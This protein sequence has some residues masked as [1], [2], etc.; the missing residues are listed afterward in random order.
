M[1][2]HSQTEISKDK[3]T[4]LTCNIRATCFVEG[5]K[6][7][8]DGCCAFVVAPSLHLLDYTCPLKD[9]ETHI[10]TY[11]M[12]LSVFLNGGCEGICTWAF[13][14]ELIGVCFVWA[15][16]DRYWTSMSFPKFS[17]VKGYC[18]HLKWLLHG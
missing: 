10:A 4:G 3:L 5:W 14:T 13:N 11:G 9:N 18:V 7:K 15:N 16:T 17:P 1:I 2:Y 12:R 6:L 8:E